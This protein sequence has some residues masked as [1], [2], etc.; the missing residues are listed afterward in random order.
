MMKRLSQ[1]CTLVSNTNLQRFLRNQGQ[2]NF[3][4]TF[5]PRPS[6]KTIY[7]FSQDHS[8]DK[9]IQVFQTRPSFEQISQKPSFQSNPNQGFQNQRFHNNPNSSFH[10]NPNNSH[11]NQ[12]QWRIH[13]TSVKI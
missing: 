11:H 3:K 13:I 9:R 2:S 12:I 4:P 10:N 5:Q 1:L 8:L 7:N 6:D